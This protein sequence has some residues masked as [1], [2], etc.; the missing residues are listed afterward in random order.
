[1][2]TK[3]L[4]IWYLLSPFI[5]LLL[6]VGLVLRKLWIVFVWIYASLTSFKRIILFLIGITLKFRSC[7][8]FIMLLILFRVSPIIKIRKFWLLLLLIISPL[9]VSIPF[10]LNIFIYFFLIFLLLSRPSL[11]SLRKSSK[12]SEN[13]LRYGF[14]NWLLYFKI[15]EC[16]ILKIFV[17][18]RR[19]VH[20][21]VT[22]AHFLFWL[23]F[24]LWSL[25]LSLLSL[26]LN[27]PNIPMV[28][29]VNIKLAIL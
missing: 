17:V 9:I 15:L 25:F 14:S 10:L 12:L 6:L 7:I 24:I 19:R 27:H 22:K 3:I 21:K 26:N 2:I 11:S 4:L 16:K 28:K 18:L 23:K 1:M 20:L 8:P 29:I 5:K 13:I